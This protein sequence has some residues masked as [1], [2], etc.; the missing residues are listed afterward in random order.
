[1]KEETQPIRQHRF[2]PEIFD[3][4]AYLMGLAPWPLKVLEHF[5][6]TWTPC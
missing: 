5:P 6:G 4:A 3:F 2:P 1:M